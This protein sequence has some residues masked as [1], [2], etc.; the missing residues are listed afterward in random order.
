MKYNKEV[1]LLVGNIGNG[2]S[3]LAKTYATKGFVII[4]RDALRYMMGAGD[5][6]FDRDLESV[7][8]KSELA[9][10]RNFMKKGVNLVIDEIGINKKLRARYLKEAKRHGYKTRAVVLYRLP[11]KESVD[12]RMKDPHGQF[13]RKLWENVWSRFDSQYT[14]PTLE[15]GFTKIIWKAK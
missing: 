10:V 4:A 12:R 5:Y 8:F 7:V 3:T 13:N 9:L 15:E 2:K 1:I 11:M 14:E 6:V